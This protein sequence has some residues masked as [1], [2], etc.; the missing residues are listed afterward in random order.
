MADSNETAY[1]LNEVSWWSNWTKARW[2]SRNAYVLFSQ[3][4]D[5]YFFNRGGFL[6]ITPDSNK[7]I[8]PMEKEFEARKRRPH[9][10]LQSDQLDSK[11]LS[12]LAKRG[13]RIADQMA[14][15]EMDEPSFKVNP[16]LKIEEEVE[17]GKL[18]S[19]ASIYLDSFYGETSQMKAVT[20]ILQRLSG[21]N[22]ASLLIGTIKGEPA[23]VTALFK[24]GKVCG[25]Y[26]VATQHEW[27]GRHVA[28]TMLDFSY[29]V[30]VEEGRKLI[31]QTILSDS[32]EVLYTKLGF[33]RAYLKDLFVKDAGGS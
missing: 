31:L 16:D 5:E 7:S 3:E 2:L 23:G 19:W 14:V 22:E 9:L 17:G 1:E 32:L 6:K 20:A 12:A 10:L 33:K 25:A 8:E 27:R 21:A 4:F 15:M 11:L 24:T 18:E 29:R 28:S 26:C 30:A 13:Y